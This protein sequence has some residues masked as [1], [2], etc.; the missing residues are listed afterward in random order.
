MGLVYIKLLIVHIAKMTIHI[1]YRLDLPPPAQTTTGFPTSCRFLADA[2]ARPNE[3]GSRHN[4][5]CST[6]LSLNT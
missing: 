1:R 5:R 4:T 2:Y 6:T 3:Q